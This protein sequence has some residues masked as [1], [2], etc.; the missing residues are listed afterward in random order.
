MYG[1]FFSIIVDIP[2]LNAN[3]VDPHQTP[4]YT[5]FANVSLKGR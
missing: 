1:L 4:R 5:H 2:V 3:R